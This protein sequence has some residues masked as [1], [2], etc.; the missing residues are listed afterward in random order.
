MLLSKWTENWLFQLWTKHV[1]VRPQEHTSG[2]TLRTKGGCW[3]LVFVDTVRPLGAGKAWSHMFPLSWRKLETPA[4]G[5]SKGSAEVWQS[6]RRLWGSNTIGHPGPHDLWGHLSYIMPALHLLILFPSTSSRG[7]DRSLLT[8]LSERS[9]GPAHSSNSS[10]LQGGELQL[11]A[12]LYQG[13]LLAIQA[14]Q[15]SEQRRDVLQENFKPPTELQ[16]QTE[17]R[18]PH[19]QQ[20]RFHRTTNGEANSFSPF[21]GR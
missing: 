18:R 10:Q 1:Q 13:N 4:S 6:D 16:S 3:D 19:Y 21:H 9:S 11:P 14:L 5:S 20:R 2:A 17:P 12:H 15:T 8:P 7:A